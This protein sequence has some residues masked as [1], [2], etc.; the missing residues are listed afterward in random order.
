MA[1]KIVTNSNYAM[2]ENNYVVLNTHS[3]TSTLFK[4]SDKQHNL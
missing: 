1:I 2:E 3:F 4:K